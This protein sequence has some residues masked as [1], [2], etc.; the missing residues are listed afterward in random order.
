M[1]SLVFVRAGV[2]ALAGALAA[3]LASAGASAADARVE[4]SVARG[5]DF[6]IDAD[7]A[8]TY[9]NPILHSDY[10]DPDV[11]RVGDRYYMVAS[12][13]H[14]SPGL[15]VLESRDLVHWT[16][17]G[18][19]LSRLD[20]HPSYDLPGPVE[21]DDS[22]ERIPFNTDM[23]HRYA[24]GVWAPAIRHHNGRFYVYFATPT[25]GVFMA[26][27]EHAAGPWSAPVKVIDEPNLEDPCPFWDDDGNAYLIHSRVGAGPLILRRMSADGTKVLD[28]GKLVME[29]KERLPILEGPKLLKRDGYYYIFAPYGGVGSGPQ[30][31]LR[32]RNIYGP[33]EFR[34]VLSKGTTNV[35]AP[36][37]GGYVETPS[38]E[39]WFLHFN[40]TGAYGRIVHMQ[41]VRWEDGWP[42]MGE[43]LPGAPHGQP[44]MSHRVPDVG[45]TFDPVF[46]Q[47]SDEF[48]GTSLG[49]QWE[50]NHNPVDS[51]WSLRGRRGHLRLKAL[52]AKNLV[53]ARNTL[54]Q[55]LH[56][57]SSQIT[58]RILVK[59]MRDGQKAGLAMFGK[60]P[61]WIGLTQQSGKRLLTFS[62]AGE[63][64]H[65]EVI[66]AES[67]LLRVD[68]DDELARYSYS[69]DEG[70]TFK[71]FG[72]RARLLFSWWKG[73]RPALFTFNTN[74]SGGGVV[75]FD[76]VRVEDTSID[77]RALLER[78]NPTLT[79]IDPSAPLMV[80]NGNIGFTA[81]ITGLQ[82]FRDEYSPLAPL[83]IQAQ[84]A[85]HSFPNR[86]QFK[87]EDSLVPVDV[88]GKQQLF[89][90]LRDWSEAKRPAIQWLRENPHRFSLGR[91]SL[92]LL[93]SD[94]QPARFSDLKA[95]RQ[96]LDL[97]SGTLRSRFELESRPV[98][99]ETSVHPRLDLILVRMNAPGFA[100]A[101]LGVDLKFPGVAAQLN[102]DPADW[103]H[104][105]RHVTEVLGKTQR[106]ISLRRR[107]DDTRYFVEA[108]S[109]E[110]VTF[111]SI[112]PHVIRVLPK[113]ND[114]VFT[115]SVLFSPQRHEGAL[116]SSATTRSA[117]TSHW[118][119]HWSNGGIID[120]SGSTDPRAKEL[121]RRVVLS[122]YL[123]AINA[124]G[125]LPPQE[126]GLFSNSWNGKFHVEM[127]PWHAAH[128]ALWGR[129][130]L[131]ERS[132]PWYQQHL[133]HAKARAA[134][135]GL[136]GAWWPKMVGPEGR[137][138][139]ST[140]NPFLMWQQPHPIFLAELIYRDRPNSATLEQYRALV[141]ETAEL[142]ASYPHY[143]ASRD[144]Y[145]L[146]PPLIP[147][148]EVFPPL[149][150]SN[151]TFELE[152]FRFGLATAQSWR[153]RLN[154]PR[155]PEWDRVLEKLSPL[156]Q[157]DGLYLAVESFPR[158]WEQA[159]SEQ[160]S[161]GRTAPEC[162]NRDHPSLLGALGLLPGASVDRETMRRTLRAVEQSWDL[163]QTWGWDFPLLAM[164]AARLHEP[165]K[166]VDFLLYPSRN[167]QF[168]V[169]GMT[170][171]VHL[172]Q[173]AA[174]LVPT[175]PAQQNADAGYR[176]LA[177]TYFP[178]NGG[179]LLAVGMMAAG[180]DGEPSHLP[181]FPKEGW[182][183]RAQG[184][185]PLP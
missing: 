80:G 159:R 41:P 173:H 143:D 83:P 107:I 100:A 119:A 140:I 62:Y 29:D 7:A 15:P 71:P 117:V 76:W 114:G 145:V 22:T 170:P 16:L 115:L 92:H 65:G 88:R 36:H 179:L 136:R 86:Q 6:E 35:Q 28:A 33:Y 90:W 82:T 23:G 54:T 176:R 149:S 126:E 172:D 38:G 44:V 11:I 45:S 53:S 74:E 10:S 51:H 17:I 56:G 1:K 178:S 2:L 144:R 98:E 85:W 110:D 127:H 139:P 121:E 104:P 185:R 99:I 87:Y 70:R 157:R 94:G 183:V 26:S 93:R 105:Q 66:S 164:T 42:I 58:A 169:T 131:L 153:E 171:R 43:L 111:E 124:A 61:S 123:M 75:D 8:P 40:S 78:H 163:R 154:L 180:W 30:A 132:M 118:E 106:Q 184:L 141:F 101:Q 147:A 175:F 60:R 81:D 161:N 95:T 59:G 166:A 64:T 3:T 24:A 4:P 133:P 112:E 84:W 12:T 168:G 52:P 37:Q 137:E 27:A 47:T 48:D 73:A 55:V 125:S 77:R 122:Q 79:G 151:P 181:G 162:W 108:A 152:Y 138:S 49:V 39:G 21:F 9:R 128:F 97:W 31:V 13:F 167:F 130:E 135:H 155:K 182:Q 129:T 103:H 142:L 113:T 63:D 174:D 67:L 69:V 148:Q 160:C 96:T 72:T 89:P 177:E 120:F 50:W 20:F 156:P 165:E 25:E 14:F 34:T 116:P 19:V 102:P 5:A 68:V 109:D 32:S 134:S 91:I 18:H 146:G 150:T 158:Q 57:R 46:V